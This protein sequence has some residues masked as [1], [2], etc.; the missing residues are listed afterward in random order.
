MLYNGNILT[1]APTAGSITC[2]PSASEAHYQGKTVPCVPEQPTSHFEACDD[3]ARQ[4]IS[5]LLH[6]TECHRAVIYSSD[7]QSGVLQPPLSLP[8]PT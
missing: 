3:N 7:F 5:V 1:V 4:S 8:R 2:V 6:G